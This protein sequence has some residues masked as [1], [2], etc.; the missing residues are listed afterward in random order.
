MT[1]VKQ[2]AIATDQAP[3]AIGP[4]S[5]A[6]RAG[7]FIYISGQLP[8]NPAV[9]AIEA[10]DAAGQAA[11]AIDNL[12]AILREAGHSLANIVKATVFLTDIADFAAVNQVY[13]A[14]FTSD[15]KP[16]RA[17]FQVSA[18]PAGAAVEI[19]AVAYVG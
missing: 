5:Q 4:Y 15:P 12:E 9:G 10:E 6:V 11:Q 8:I 19:E 3:A 16:A 17:A 2:T 1:L 7:D 14:R 13:A 18:L